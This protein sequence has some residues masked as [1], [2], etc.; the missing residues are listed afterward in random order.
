MTSTI[1]NQKRK[2]KIEK[3]LHHSS[4]EKPQNSATANE[5]KVDRSLLTLPWCWCTWSGS[6]DLVTSTSVTTSSSITPGQPTSSFMFVEFQSSD[7]RSL[8]CIR[9]R[10]RGLLQLFQQDDVLAR[11]QTVASGS[12]AGTVRL[13]DVSIGEAPM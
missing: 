2:Y 13:Q 12:R 11:R 8:G 10:G 7:C 4:Q 9:L 5:F 1:L 3:W 6:V